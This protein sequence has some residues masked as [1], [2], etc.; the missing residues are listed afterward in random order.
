MTKIYCPLSMLAEP[1]EC[2]DYNGSGGTCCN[3]LPETMSKIATELSDLV[4]VLNY[5]ADM[6]GTS[7]IASA[8]DGVAD[9]LAEQ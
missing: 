1:R 4:S 8:I 3:C 5:P 9:A 6:F 7:D 2:V